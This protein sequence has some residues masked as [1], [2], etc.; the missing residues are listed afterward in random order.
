MYVFVF[1]F[2]ARVGIV[3]LYPYTNVGVNV[4]TC[5]YHNWVNNFGAEVFDLTISI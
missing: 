4:S 5:I 1:L 3:K 2:R